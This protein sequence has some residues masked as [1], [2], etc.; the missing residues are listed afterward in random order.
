MLTPKKA[1][2]LTIF[3]PRTATREADTCTCKH[4]NR[5]R[6]VRSSDPSI[7]LD[8]GGLCWC[9]RGWI[10]TPCSGALAKTGCIPFEEKLDL[11]E[12]R[13]DLFRK[14]GLSL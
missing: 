9:C 7:P 4:C 2:Y 13:Q 1:G 11:Y 14:M 5:V 8:K 6:T 3:G 12:K 10:C